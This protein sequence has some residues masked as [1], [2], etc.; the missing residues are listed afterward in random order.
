[1]PTRPRHRPGLPFFLLD[2]S[3]RPRS[4]RFTKQR[5]E[6]AP[7]VD[8]IAYIAPAGL[9]AAAYPLARI[10]SALA[11]LRDSDPAYDRSG[12]FLVVTAPQHCRP[13]HLWEQP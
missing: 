3:I 6:P 8:R 13:L 4:S 10:K 11:A 9:R 2:R 12:S 7:S 5:D 1:M